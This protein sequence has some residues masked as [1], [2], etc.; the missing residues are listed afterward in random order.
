MVQ[1]GMIALIVKLNKIGRI[2]RLSLFIRSR[3]GPGRRG[4]R[5]AGDHPLSAHFMDITS[6]KCP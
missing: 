5:G 3:R 2:S 6:T 4:G 1:Y